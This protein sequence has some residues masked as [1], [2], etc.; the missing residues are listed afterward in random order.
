MKSTE[1]EINLFTVL[2]LHADDHNLTVR[3]ICEHKRR[4]IY[5][6]VFECETADSATADLIILIFQQIN[7]ACKIL[8]DEVRLQT[9]HRT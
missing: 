1:C 8:C 9:A 6:H 2:K 5:Y 3:D 4:I 7:N